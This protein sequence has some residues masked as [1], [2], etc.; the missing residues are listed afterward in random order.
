MILFFLVPHL[1]ILGWYFRQ[2]FLASLKV[3]DVKGSYWMYPIPIQR[4]HRIHGTG[5]FTYIFP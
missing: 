5:I 2:K 1:Q 4:T 3:S